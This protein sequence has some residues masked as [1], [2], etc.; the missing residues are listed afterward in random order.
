MF[1]SDR[2][3]MVG[4]IVHDETGPEIE[5]PDQVARGNP[6]AVEVVTFGSRICH[7]EGKTEVEK[8]G[9]TA[10]ISLS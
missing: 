7:E 1:G 5:I 4:V 9:L 8:A 6:F 3:E 2:V 10:L